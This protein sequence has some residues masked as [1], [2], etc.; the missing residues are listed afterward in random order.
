MASLEFFALP[1]E[2]RAWI[3]QLLSE[4]G[5]WSITRDLSGEMEEE[6]ADA[7]VARLRFT[8]EPAFDITFGRVE[9]TEPIWRE[10]DKSGVDQVKRIDVVRSCAIQFEP[11]LAIDGRILLHGRI[12]ISTPAWYKHYGVDHG[13][14]SLWFRRVKRS[15]EA[16]MAKD[17]AIVL[18]LP[19]GRCVLQRG[20]R[21]TPGAVA[22]RKAGGLLKQFTSGP[23][24]FDIAQ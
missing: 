6:L 4:K 24:E 1:D 20:M 14:V 5:I 16:I 21:A 15:L 23:V 12:A 3:S 7:D 17:A 19:D 18:Q 9:V 10:S 8:H 11:C 22:W 13:S 2:Q